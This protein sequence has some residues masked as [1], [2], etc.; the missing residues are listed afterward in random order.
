MVL[1]T[2]DLFDFSMSFVQQE[3][4]SEP[5]HWPN[6]SCVPVLN[7]YFSFRTS[8]KSGPHLNSEFE[9]K[10]FFCISSF[11]L[12]LVCTVLLGVLVVFR[13]PS[14]ALCSVYSVVV[15]SPF[16]GSHCSR[17]PMATFHDAKH[18]VTYM[19]LDQARKVVI[20]VGKDKVIKVH[21]KQHS[22]RCGVPECEFLPNIHWLLGNVWSAA[23]KPKDSQ[24]VLEFWTLVLSNGF[25]YRFGTWAAYCTDTLHRELQII[26]LRKKG[27][28]EIAIRP[29][30]ERCLRAWLANI[31]PWQKQFCVEAMISVKKGMTFVCKLFISRLKS[32]RSLR[33]EM[34]WLSGRCKG[35]VK[36]HI[37][38]S[39]SFGSC[40]DDVL[41]FVVLFYAW[42][43]F[44][45]PVVNRSF[46]NW[47]HAFTF[48]VPL[49]NCEKGNF[50]SW[51]ETIFHCWDAEVDHS[52]NVKR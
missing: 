4:W 35:F 18:Q 10:R 49:R 39:E 22:P 51:P 3:N 5:N 12:V 13:S 40:Y 47:K 25:D 28:S 48:S 15:M 29:S 30:A 24:I 17:A 36:W 26:S 6:I 20:T 38:V 16:F 27:V 42:K 31:C 37:D 9:L 44:T 32:G 52:S 34:C 14:C 46:V 50:Q 8:F 41:L 1:K 2:P 19:H 43:C 21:A 45:C 33:T 7:P 11:W 23:L